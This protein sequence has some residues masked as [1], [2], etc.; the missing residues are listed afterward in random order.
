MSYHRPIGLTCLV[1]VA[2]LLSIVLTIYSAGAFFQVVSLLKHD[3]FKPDHYPLGNILFAVAGVCLLVAAWIAAITAFHLWKF[4]PRG[5]PLA[6]TGA[7]ILGIFTVLLIFN[8]AFQGLEFWIALLVL[9]LSFE[10]IVYL[11]LP[12]IRSHFEAKPGA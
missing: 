4:K 10:T 9:M 11:R 7:W 3:R 2:G 12:S 5:H 1:F 8:R 6:M